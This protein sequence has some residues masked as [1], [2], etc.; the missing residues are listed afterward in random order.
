MLD[1]RGPRVYQVNKSTLSLPVSHACHKITTPIAPRYL[2]E[3]GI[4]TRLT[5]DRIKRQEAYTHTPFPP[6]PLS[7]LLFFYL[8]PLPL[9][10]IHSQTQVKSIYLCSYPSIYLQ[11]CL[12]VYLFY[13]SIYHSIYLSNYLSIYPS[14][15]SI[16][17][18]QSI[19]YFFFNFNSFLPPEQIL[20]FSQCTIS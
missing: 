12:F 4:A 11:I 10:H 1:R 6:P 7:P 15:Y 16:V 19:S 5:K 9:H 17:F 20:P 3:L 8:L 18:Y 13:T 14:I 2:S